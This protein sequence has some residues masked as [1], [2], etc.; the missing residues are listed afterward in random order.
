MAFVCLSVSMLAASC[1]NS[2][3]DLRKNFTTDVSLP[4]KFGSRLFLCHKGLKTEKLQQHLHHT[5]YSSPFH[6][7]HP[8]LQWLQQSEA[9]YS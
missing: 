6:Q 7:P 4:V 9:I 5:V 2:L 8:L 3:S 1:K